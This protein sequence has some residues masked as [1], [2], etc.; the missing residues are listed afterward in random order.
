[1]RSQRTTSAVARDGSE[2]EV[3]G[4]GRSRRIG[5][6]QTASDLVVPLGSLGRRQRGID[7]IAHQLVPEGD[8]GAV[9]THKPIGNAGRSRPAMSS[10]A[11]P[12]TAAELRADP[13]V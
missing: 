1:L 9:V 12:V 6:G 11:R 8:V 10:G 2:C 13:D 4:D 5:A 3:F 7:G